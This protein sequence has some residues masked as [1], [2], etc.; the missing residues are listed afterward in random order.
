MKQN[1]SP[2]SL[3]LHTGLPDYSLNVQSFVR[4]QT[5]CSLAHPEKSTLGNLCKQYGNKIP[6]FFC[7]DILTRYK[8]RIYPVWAVIESY[9]DVVYCTVISVVD[10]EI[11]LCVGFRRINCYHVS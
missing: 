8:S 10:D 6:I 9:S 7:Y 4:F 3:H 5:F 2:T 11:F 1:L